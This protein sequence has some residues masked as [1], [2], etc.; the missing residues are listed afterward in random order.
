MSKGYDFYI[1]KCRL[2]VSPASLTI[3]C[4]SGSRTINLINMGEIN[5]L[6][7]PKLKTVEFCCLIPQVK[8]PFGVYESGYRPAEA[9]VE[10]F[11]KL[12]SSEK[13]FQFIVSRGMPMGK[14][15]FS[16]NIK[17]SMEDISVIE[18]WGNGFDVAVKIKLKQYRDFSVTTVKTHG[19]NS[20]ALSSQRAASTV[21]PVPVTIGCNV[22]ING[23]LYGSSF[24]DAPGQTRTN[25]RGKINFINPDGSHPYHITTPDGLWQGWVTADSVEVVT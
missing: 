10:Y 11:K 2:P 8:Y 20:G 14:R 24:G 19:L 16:T 4:G 3:T 17:V 9:Y 5:L 18:E 15:L 13:P 1:D 25:Y 21:Q 12:Q 6:N 23:R 7:K 22:I